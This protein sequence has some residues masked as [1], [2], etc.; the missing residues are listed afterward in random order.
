MSSPTMEERQVLSAVFDYCKKK[1]NE[2]YTFKHSD[3]V[4]TDGRLLPYI[5][6]KLKGR[7]GP[8]FGWKLTRKV[9]R[10][11]D[12]SLAKQKFIKKKENGDYKLM[13]TRVKEVCNCC[14]AL[15]CPN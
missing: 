14:R 12:G 13:A 4:D 9:F 1:N 6:R 2:V 10:L 5:V 7:C 3:L 11:L 8:P 15:I